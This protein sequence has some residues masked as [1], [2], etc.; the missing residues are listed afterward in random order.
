VVDQLSW[1]KSGV[2]TVLAAVLIV[3]GLSVVGVGVHD[4]Y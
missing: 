2:K 1:R 3:V 4:D